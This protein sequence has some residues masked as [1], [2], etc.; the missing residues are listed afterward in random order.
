M[1]WRLSLVA[2]SLPHGPGRPVVQ[3]RRGH[4]VHPA[5]QVQGGAQLQRP[6]RLRPDQGGAGPERR[7]HGETTLRSVAPGFNRTGL[8]SERINVSP[9]PPPL[10]ILLHLLCPLFIYFLFNLWTCCWP[11]PPS[12]SSSSREP[13]GPWSSLTA[14]G[15][16]PRRARTT[17][18]VSGCWRRPLTTS[19][20]CG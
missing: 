9:H 12:S 6:L 3:R 1:K 11:A 5:S 15:C 2:L 13:S 14:G 19:T 10:L 17:W 18:S 7:A 16:W 20:T 4:A 8:A